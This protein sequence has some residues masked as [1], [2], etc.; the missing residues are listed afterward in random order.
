MMLWRY[1]MDKMTNKY[2]HESKAAFIRSFNE[3]NRPQFNR[4]L[5]TRDKY[6]VIDALKKI[7]LSCQRDLYFIIRVEE[8][9]VI[10]D[11]DQIQATLRSIVQEKID[12][13]KNK[14]QDNQYDFINMKD[15]A[16]MLLQIDYYIPVRDDIVRN[17]ITKQKR[18]TVTIA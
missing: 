12:R 13:N 2:N 15:S 9:R 14:K 4:E 8:F 6:E 7:A 11:Y 18:F 1:M 17:I 5:Y 16:I 10:E 3:Q